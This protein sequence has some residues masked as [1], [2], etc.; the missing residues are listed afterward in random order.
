MHIAVEACEISHKVTSELRNKALS[1]F[2]LEKLLYLF[3]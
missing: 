3:Y 1:L 2:K